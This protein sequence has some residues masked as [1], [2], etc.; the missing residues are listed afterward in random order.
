MRRTVA[1]V[2]LVLASTGCG[3]GLVEACW[4]FSQ[5]P[6]LRLLDQN[7]DRRYLLMGAQSGSAF[8]NVGASFVFQPDSAI[9]VV[10]HFDIRGAW[11]KEYEYELRTNNFGLAQAEDIHAGSP[12]ILI[13]GDSYTEGL[14]A[15]PWFETTVPFFR[16]QGYQPING[17]L[18]GTGFKQWRLLH[19]H[20][21]T[22]GIRIAKLVVVLISG[23]YGRP[24]WN[25]PAQTLRCSGNHRDCTGGE[26]LYGLPPEPE[27]QAFLERMRHE[28]RRRD[29]GSLA[30]WLP[31]TDRASGQALHLLDGVRDQFEGWRQ[32]TPVVQSGD[33]LDAAII[34]EFT[35]LYGENVTFVHLPTR[36][37]LRRGLDRDG[38][39]V[40]AAIG[41][42]GAKVLRWVHPLWAYGRRLS[43]E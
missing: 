17:G 42:A 5:D 18:A 40:R 26:A 16:E 32:Q 23:D 24:V 19:D 43:P 6:E 2:L 22:G 21:R 38:H 31:A 28:R 20:L 25:W 8:Q 27:R 39:A 14:G 1:R 12:S 7:F 41:A 34:K 13:L 9:R 15:E 29:A 3:V 11:V 37:E 33:H 10:M 30:N 35:D 36:P 4:Y